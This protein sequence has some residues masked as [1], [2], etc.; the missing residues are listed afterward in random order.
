[1]RDS[2]Q[3]AGCFTQVRLQ[4]SLW[5]FGR[6]RLSIHVM[7]VAYVDQPMPSMEGAQH[8]C[9]LMRNLEDLLHIK[10]TG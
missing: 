6:A 1:M 2:K 10:K 5:C 3:A 9:A 7:D 8:F 4:L